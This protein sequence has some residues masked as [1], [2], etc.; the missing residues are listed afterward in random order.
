MASKKKPVATVTTTD[1]TINGAAS[2]LEVVNET[3]QELGVDARM[4]LDL[5]QATPTG[6]NVADTWATVQAIATALGIDVRFAL[7]LY[8]SVPADEPEPAAA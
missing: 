4:A 6:S 2:V 1:K 8:T 7:D 3:A 5:H